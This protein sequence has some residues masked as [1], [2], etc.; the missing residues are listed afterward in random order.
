MVGI[1]KTE[2]SL[3]TQGE[4][5]HVL[6]S[7][8]NKNYLQGKAVLFKGLLSLTVLFHIIHVYVSDT[9]NFG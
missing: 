5:Q 9:L 4:I 8:L 6:L 7:S 2:N 3:L 1:L